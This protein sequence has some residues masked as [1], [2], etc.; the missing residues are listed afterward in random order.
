MEWRGRSV[1]RRRRKKGESLK[2][3][4][5]KVELKGEV[6]SHKQ[7]EEATPEEE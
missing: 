5:K 6:R 7:T 3:K 1:T 4:T 2:K